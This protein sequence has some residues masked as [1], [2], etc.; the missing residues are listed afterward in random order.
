ML[1]IFRRIVCDH[2]FL[3]K[4]PGS[5]TPE[6]Y[7]SYLRRYVARLDLEKHVQLLAAVLEI[8]EAT[9]GGHILTIE[10]PE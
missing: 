7:V 2:P 8:G 3:A 4:A 10:K 9:D 1:T 6:A 5:A